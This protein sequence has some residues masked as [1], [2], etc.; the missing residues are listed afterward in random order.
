MICKAGVTLE[1]AVKMM[2]EVPAKVMGIYSQRGSLGEGK[3][4]DITV[5]DNN[6]NVLMTMSEGDVVYSII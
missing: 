2:T 4:A 6:I 3:F 1:S 5:F